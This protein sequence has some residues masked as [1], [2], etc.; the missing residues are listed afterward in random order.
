[1]N[2]TA[3]IAILLAGSAAWVTPALGAPVGTAFNYQGRLTMAGSPVNT[4]VDFEFQLFDAAVG[5]AAIGS[6]VTLSAVPVNQGLFTV[7][8]D[9]G[10]G[11]HDGTGRWLS[12]SVRNA[13]VGAYTLLT[14]RE[15]LRPVSYAAALPGFWTDENGTSPNIV[16]GHADNSFASGVVGATI[17]GGGQI[18]MVNTASA[19]FS[20]IAGGQGNT[21]TGTN[22]TVGGGRANSAGQG[23]VVSGGLQNSATGQW[24]IVPGGRDNVASA[25]LSFASGRRAKAIHTGA[26][27]MADSS[28]A[29]IE[30]T[31]DNQ[32][33]VRA[34]SGFRLAD[35]AGSQLVH[36]DAVSGSGGSLSLRGAVPG[37]FGLSV[38]ASLAQLQAAD[39]EGRLTL[40]RGSTGGLT[41]TNTSVAL[42]GGD[43]TVRADG[44]FELVQDGFLGAESLRA[45][46]TTGPNSGGNLHLYRTVTNGL[47]SEE[48]D[49]ALMIAKA[50]AGGGRIELYNLSALGSP[51]LQSVF[52]P[53]HVKT[54]GTFNVVDNIDTAFEE[55]QA[56][57]GNFLQGGRLSL[58][59]DDGEQTVEILGN[60]AS[61]QGSSLKMFDSAGNLTIELDAE[62]GDGGEGRV[63][64]GVLE[65]TGGSDLSEQFDINPGTGNGEQ[66]TGVEPGLLVSIDPQR[67][68]E[69][70]VSSRAYDRTVA[71]VVSGAGGV[72][73]GML[74]GQS[75]SRADGA[76]PVALT[77]R[78]YCWADASNGAIEP[79]DL[80]TTSEVLGHAMKATEPSRSQGAIIGKAMTALSEGRGLVLVLVN[81]Q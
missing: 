25:E 74:M 16:G 40:R 20:T 71:G 28:D 1:M 68:G 7:A 62:H 21:V 42:D 33:L 8:I 46:L 43:G 34:S 22:A 56:E 19:S 36:M 53:L 26:Y 35:G 81:L 66:G 69:L 31:A 14:P 70:I 76:H 2:R 38:L 50:T 29:D 79:G 65:I 61:D 37:D 75:G 24:A 73:T 45:T 60:E 77:G 55:P 5:G 9:F 39:A 13:G 18:G 48:T 57:L 64:T 47:T 10:D 11:S 27:V 41:N 80:L 63:I 17:G 49:E 30:S 72:R 51:G 3:R 4:P 54:S 44:G 59:D 67:A 78:V 15:E 58:F 32:F 6:T 12:I 23:A 52:E